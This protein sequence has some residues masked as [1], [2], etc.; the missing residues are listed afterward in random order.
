VRDITHL[1]LR[2]QGR[3]AQLLSFFSHTDNV[4]PSPQSGDVD[5]HK[6]VLVGLVRSDIVVSLCN[7]VR[8]HASH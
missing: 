3:V 6:R 1:I 4:L 8:E 2:M 7:T 5:G